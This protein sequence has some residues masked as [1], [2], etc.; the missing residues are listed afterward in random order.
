MRENM[1]VEWAKRLPRM[2]ASYLAR[3]RGTEMFARKVTVLLAG[4]ALVALPFAAIAQ[5]KGKSG[6]GGASGPTTT[7]PVGGSQGPVTIDNL[8]TR[9]TPLAG[10]ADNATSLVNGLRNG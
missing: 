7:V 6:N 9:Y 4:A 1:P 3:H 5:G 2:A 10:S 8:I